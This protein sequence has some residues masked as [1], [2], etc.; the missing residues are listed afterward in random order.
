LIIEERAF[1]VIV[2]KELEIN[3][4]LAY[5]ILGL[6]NKGLDIVDSSNAKFLPVRKIKNLLVKNPRLLVL[7]KMT[8]LNNKANIITQ[9]LISTIYQ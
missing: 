8:D 3:S 1:I 9:I 7:N 6:K 2:N 5:S 4:K